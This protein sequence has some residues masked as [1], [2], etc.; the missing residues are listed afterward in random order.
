MGALGAVESRR[1]LNVEGSPVGASAAGAH[2]VVVV[3]SRRA[4]KVAA[5][6]E[7]PVSPFA[8]SSARGR[9]VATERRRA[10]KLEAS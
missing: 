9:L 7:R 4:L 6:L 3:E 10:L 1:A 8:S 2:S 5:S